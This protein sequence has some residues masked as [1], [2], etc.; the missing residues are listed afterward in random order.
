MQ[1]GLCRH[2]LVSVFGSVRRRTFANEL[3]YAAHLR[4]N[5]LAALAV[6][7]V[8]TGQLDLRSLGQR[9]WCAE[10]TDVFNAF[11]AEICRYT[12]YH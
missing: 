7:E 8:V 6:T 2:H 5:P 1:A 9:L 12:G 10:K 4:Q 11:D 3:R